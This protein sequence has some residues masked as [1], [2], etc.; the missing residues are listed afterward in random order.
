MV[1]IM[2]QTS[3][4]NECEE[5]IRIIACG[6]FKPALEHIY[7]ESQYPNVHL[8]YLPP[9]L[10][11]QPGEL[12]KNLRKEIN[13]AKS[14]HELVICLYGECFPG[15]NEYCKRSGIIK[16]PGLHCWEMLLGSEL[17]ERL[18]EEKAGTYFLEK[19]LILNFEEACIQPL[20]LYDEEMRSYCFKHYDRLLYVRQPSDPDLVQRVSEIAEFLG[21][22]PELKDADYSHLEL[23]LKKILK[24]RAPE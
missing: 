18:I 10:H 3:Q 14:R 17:Y 1:Y 24:V 23:K 13:N 15:I 4:S 5:H 19:E 9:Y 12:A 11:L 16:V 8:T 20:E 6:V 21:L 2:T 22:S 7:L